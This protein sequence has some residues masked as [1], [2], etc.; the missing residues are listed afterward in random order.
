MKCSPSSGSWSP[1]RSPRSTIDRKNA[2]ERDLGALQSTRTG[3][4]YSLAPQRPQCIALRPSSVPDRR[5]M[6][7]DL[8]G[9]V[10]V[11]R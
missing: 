9:Y 11:V 3:I 2:V 8:C 5:L 7:V 6:G 10:A 1:S 4:T